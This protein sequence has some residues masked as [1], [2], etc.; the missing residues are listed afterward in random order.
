MVYNYRYQEALDGETVIPLNFKSPFGDDSFLDKE[1]FAIYYIA[2]IDNKSYSD[3]DL[4]ILPLYSTLNGNYF[5][6]KTILDFNKDPIISYVDNTFL[7][8][9]YWDTSPQSFINY[10]T[11]LL[12]SYKVVKGRP[13]SP[14]SFSSLDSY[15]NDRREYLVEIPFTRYDMINRSWITEDDFVEEF[16]V[17]KKLLYEDITSTEALLQGAEYYDGQLI[18]TGVIYLDSVYVNWSSSYNF[19]LLNESLYSWEINSNGEL[20]IT[21][22]PHSEGDVFR[23]VYY[24]LNPTPIIHSLNNP[25]SIVDSIKVI[26]SSG[27]AYEFQL[28]TDYIISED[29]YRVYFKDIYNSIL[30]SGNFSIHDKFEIRYHA[31]LSRKIDLSQNLL[32]TL[33]D[34][35]GNNIPIDNIPIDNLGLFEYKKVLREDSPLSIPLGSGKKLV[36]LD[37]KYLPLNIF[38]KSAAQLMNINYTGSDFGKIYPYIESNA[39]A[40]PITIITIPKKVKL[41]MIE[42]PSQNIIINQRF[43][44]ERD[45]YFNLNPVEALYCFARGMC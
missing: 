35:E 34:S 30:E 29:G 21:N 27:F 22:L 39:W 10:D 7:L 15:G 44:E 37:L 16:I 24:G 42:D 3:N 45:Y 31:P 43:Y 38:N 4:E 2:N 6:N 14:L 28:G 26:N 18:Q 8:N 13:I 33:Q 11:E 19:E 25:A 23:A 20:N 5:K 40:K 36:H 12:I 1:E 17:D 9:I 32:L 41:E